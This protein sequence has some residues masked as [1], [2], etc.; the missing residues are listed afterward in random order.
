MQSRA[1]S[2]FHSSVSQ[3]MSKKEQHPKEDSRPMQDKEKHDQ[4]NQLQF[5]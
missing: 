4:N 5:I 2:T 1:G 3:Q